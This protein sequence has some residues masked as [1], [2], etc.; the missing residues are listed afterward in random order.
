MVVIS[1]GDRFVVECVCRGHAPSAKLH[2]IATMEYG[3][4]MDY[5]VG[6]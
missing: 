3:V 6:A 4:S 5:G 2:E 1:S